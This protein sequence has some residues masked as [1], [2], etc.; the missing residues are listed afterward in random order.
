MDM[1]RVI[2]AVVI[3]ATIGWFAFDKF[4]QKPHQ[5][6]LNGDS[7]V[8]SCEKL[9]QSLNRIGSGG[10]DAAAKPPSKEQRVEQAC[11]LHVCGMSFMHGRSLEFH[12]AESLKL[13]NGQRDQ[14]V[15]LGDFSATDSAGKTEYGFNCVVSN[16]GLDQAAPVT[17]LNAG[18][19]PK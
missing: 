15:M 4:I 13:N 11:R 7:N 6:A 1:A 18:V 5:D 12:E 17:V 3:A 19:T 8:I 14:K 16:V 10:G 9:T 2:P